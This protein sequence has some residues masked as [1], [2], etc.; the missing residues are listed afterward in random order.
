[1]ATVIVTFV[2]VAVFP[3]TSRATAVS[4]C[5]P[6]VVVRE[7]QTR[8]YGLDVSSAPRMAPS[9][10]KA[11]LLVRPPETLRPPMDP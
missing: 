6:F 10:R 5:G 3:A 2:A 9:S 4:V 7:F 11:V 8:P 1:M